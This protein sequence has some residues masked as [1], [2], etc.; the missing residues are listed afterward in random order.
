MVNS[1]SQQ[2]VSVWD[3]TL[4]SCDWLQCS[5]IYQSDTHLKTHSINKCNQCDFVYSQTGDLRKHLKRRSGEKPNKCNQSDYGSSPAEHL[6]T[7]LKK[8]TVEKSHIAV[9]LFVC[10]LSWPA[11]YYYTSTF[12]GPIWKHKGGEIFNKCYRCDFVSSYTTFLK[13]HLT[14][15]VEKVQQ[16]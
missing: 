16:M 3:V 12:W 4:S 6:R 14:T 5:S 11:T 2:N 1:F 9:C 13:A 10:L 7:R 15:H 8:N